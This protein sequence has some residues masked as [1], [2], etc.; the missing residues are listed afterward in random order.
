MYQVINICIIPFISAFFLIARQ[1]PVGQGLPPHY[2]GFTITFRQTTLS[3]TPLVK[4]SARHKDLFLKT[5][6]KR[7]GHSCPRLDLNPQSQRTNSAADPH[8]RPCG[9]WERPINTQRTEYSTLSYLKK[10][11][12]LCVHDEKLHCM[13]IH[14]IDGLINLAASVSDVLCRW[15]SNSVNTNTRSYMPYVLE[16]IVKQDRQCTYN[17]TFEARSFN[18]CCSGKAMS[19]T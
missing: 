19:I 18:H 16:A 7:D 4:W 10:T 15:A 5:Q 1:S 11:Y 9:H 8:L 2:R 17:V 14:T 6:N 12:F 13:K 3:R